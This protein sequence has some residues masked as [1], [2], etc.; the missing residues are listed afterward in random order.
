MSIANERR[1]DEKALEYLNSSYDKFVDIMSI[2]PDEKKCS[3]LHDEMISK[4]CQPVLLKLG[5]G[6]VGSLD[7]LIKNANETKPAV[8]NRPDVCDELQV[9]FDLS[10]SEYFILYS[11]YTRLL[12]CHCRLTR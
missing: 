6:V 11:K 7:K 10:D 5:N 1:C 4:Q 2:K 3:S 8:E 12:C 9:I